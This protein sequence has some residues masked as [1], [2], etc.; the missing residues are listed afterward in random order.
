MMANKRGGCI[1]GL[2][3]HYEYSELVTIDDL[4]EH[5]EDNIEFNKSLD[6]DP[7]LRNA[8]HLRAKVWTLRNY[9]DWR[10]KTNLTR[11]RYCP[12]CGEFVDWGVIRRMHDG[13]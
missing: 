9:G 12:E 2:L 8:K 5:I 10:K 7:V 1:I 6:D 3:H 11:F 13:K 4:K